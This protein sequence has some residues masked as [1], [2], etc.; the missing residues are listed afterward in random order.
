MVVSASQSVCSLCEQRGK[1]GPGDAWQ[2]IEDRGVTLLV[3]LPRCGFPVL[4]GNRL[5]EHFAEPVEL[6]PGVGELTVDEPYPID[7]AAD[8]GR[9]GLDCVRRNCQSAL[10]QLAQYMGRTEAADAV[11]LEYPGDGLLTHIGSHLGRR[12]S[13]EQIE[14][15]VRTDIVSELQ[16]LWIIAPELMLE[17][18]GETDV[19][20]LELLVNARPFP[21]LDDD[22][23][24][25]GAFAECS[26]VGPEAV[27]QHI[28]V[29]AVVLDPSDREAKAVELFGVDGINVE[30]ALEQGL[31]DRPVRCF[32]GDMDLARFAR[33]PSA[34]R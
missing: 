31:D 23:L 33:S 7:Q 3:F 4:L 9:R 1:D 14:K 19:L 22:G 12:H 10:A 30:T 6:P 32:D 13:L 17:A 16:H 5:R 11:V 21:E 34:T 18:V 25:D 27:R 28:G 29:T 20:N 15:P 26:H 2:R 8:A 24:G